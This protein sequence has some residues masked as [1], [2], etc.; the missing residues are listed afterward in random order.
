MKNK[1]TAIFC[2]VLFGIILFQFL[3]YKCESSKLSKKLDKAQLELQACINAPVVTRT[4][5]IRD[6]LTRVIHI[7]VTKYEV[8]E[9]IEIVHDTVIETREY[10]GTYTH[11][12]FELHWS[13]N[14]TGQLNDLSIQ[15]PSL[16]KSLV[17]TKEKTV[18]LT[19]YQ[20][21]KVR[22]KSHLYTTFGGTVLTDKF[23]GMDVGLMYIRREGWG[24][25]AGLSTDFTNMM[26][27]GGIVI[28]LK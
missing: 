14:V 28:K 12:Q 7:P 6:T 1:V 23:W 2:G 18:D 25:S 27:R 3:F 13:A 4:D 22:E 21:E 17:I 11:P 24:I 8:A 10:T 9:R 26:Y 20:T 19:Q 5:T 16:I 15:P